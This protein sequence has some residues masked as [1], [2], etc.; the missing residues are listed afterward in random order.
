MYPAFLKPNYLLNNNSNIFPNQNDK[1]PDRNQIGN[2]KPQL[3]FI[4]SINISKKLLFEFYNKYKNRHPKIINDCV[5]LLINS[6]IFYA[7]YN[8]SVMAGLTEW[9]T[10][11][12]IITVNVDVMR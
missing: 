11:L 1:Y 3:F 5:K 10:N 2:M 8:R 12:M 9:L 6:L 7:G 4:D